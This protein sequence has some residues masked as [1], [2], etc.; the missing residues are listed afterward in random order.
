[1][2][3]VHSQKTLVASADKPFRGRLLSLA[4]L[5]TLS[6]TAILGANI[7]SPAFLDLGLLFEKPES[8]I[9]LTLTI[10]LI[11][12]GLGQLMIGPVFD[13]MS[14]RS[15][16]WAALGVFLLGSIVCLWAPTLSVLYIGRFI[17]GFGVAGC[18][19]L[20]RLLAMRLFPM[21]V[22]PRAIARVGSVT[23]VVSMATPVVGGVLVFVAGAKSVFLVSIVFVVLLLFWSRREIGDSEAPTRAATPTNKRTGIIDGY[24]QIF[25]DG[26]TC[27]LLIAVI[28]NVGFGYAYLTVA[29]HLLMGKYEL[30]SVQFGL[31]SMVIP[32]AMLLGTISNDRIV[33][34]YEK[35]V[36]LRTGATGLFIPNLV[37]LF[38][39]PLGLDSAILT[40]CLIAVAAFFGTMITNVGMSAIMARQQANG[41]SASATIG[42]SM[43]IGAFLGSSTNLATD[44]YGVGWSFTLLIVSSFPL[45]AS[46]TLQLFL[47]KS[48]SESEASL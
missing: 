1:M 47:K 28:S 3:T 40:V 23:L 34:F 8:S 21:E 29:P 20:W 18:S 33:Q 39:I 45:L 19:V 26:I 31:F 14:H 46:M 11:A 27:L 35:W 24:R 22:F 9:R 43:M 4:Y 15:V 6:A 41:G 37:I 16:L 7:V 13:R 38:S 5:A 30:D 42:V 36:M 17:Q 2:G 48:S 25:L 44:V 12:W 32:L 10:Y